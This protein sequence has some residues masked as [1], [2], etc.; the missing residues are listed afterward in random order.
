MSGG[1]GD[2]RYETRGHVGVLTLDRPEVHNALRERTYRELEEAVRGCAERVLVITG[3]GRSF[4]SGDDVRELMGGG[5]EPPSGAEPGTEPAAPR[6]LEPRLTP[7]ADALL[8]T[9]VP[10][11]A[12]VNGPA[13]GWGMELAL[14]ADLRVA[15][16][17]AR[18]GEL[19]VK[20]GLCSDVAG[21][22]RLS[23]LVGRERAAE[24]LFTGEVI[25]AER[26]VQIGLVGRLVED[27]DLMDTALALAD[28]IAANPPLAVAA[29]KSGL[30]RALDPD[31]DDLGRWVTTT[32]GGLFATEDHREGVRSFLEK[33]EPRY[34]GR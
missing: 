25:D 19:F 34:V 7:A 9:N 20:R 2:I 28:R 16:R 13:V 24:L 32:L 30:R 18:F 3:A 29:L 4:C 26:A 8:G 10:V 22:G 23:Q 12:A 11:I 27:G 6:A 31:W 33:R 5:A 1:H 17:S 14:F 21:I 15:A